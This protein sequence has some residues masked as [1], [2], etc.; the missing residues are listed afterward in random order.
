MLP[1]ARHMD[2]AVGF[3]NSPT[4]LPSTEVPEV[5]YIIAT[6]MTVLVNGIP[7]ARMFDTVMSGCG[8]SVGIIMNGSSKVLCGGLPMARLT[9]TFV[10]TFHGTIMNGSSNVLCG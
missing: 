9:D 10:G 5:G 8:T 4:H 1:V 2:M 6:Q 7:A 3:C